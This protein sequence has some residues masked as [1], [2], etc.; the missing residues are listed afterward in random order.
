MNY[1]ALIITLTTGLILALVGWMLHREAA[2]GWQPL[3]TAF[4]LRERP[5]GQQV[6][7]AWASLGGSGMVGHKG[8][9]VANVSPAGLTLQMSLF[10]WLCYPA[11]QIPWSACGPFQVKKQFLLQTSCTTFVRLPDGS[12]VPVRIRDADFVRAVQPWITV[13]EAR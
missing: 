6:R 9:V 5:T 10:A 12:S 11:M 3:A 8:M 13:E 7:L 2:A 1:L 4:P